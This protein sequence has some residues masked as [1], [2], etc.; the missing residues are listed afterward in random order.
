MMENKHTPG[1]WFVA[2]QDAASGAGYVMTGGGTYVAKP[3]I[4]VA[5]NA[6][7]IAA[8]PEL[9]EALQY[10]RNLMGPDEIIDAIL[11]KARGE[12]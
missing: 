3:L 9:M 8:A 5:A 6:H 4:N 11:S 10:A 7:L 1:P 2:G 12:A